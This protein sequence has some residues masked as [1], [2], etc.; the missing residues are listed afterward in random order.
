MVFSILKMIF[1]F[2]TNT[3]WIFFLNSKILERFLPQCTHV[4]TNVLLS[5][6][7]AII[8]CTIH[9]HLCVLNASFVNLPNTIFPFAVQ[10]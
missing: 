4:D 9:D 2:G 5:W 7:C 10:L 8:I 6:F 1:L 3:G